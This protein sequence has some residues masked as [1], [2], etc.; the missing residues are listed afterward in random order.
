ML[1][2]P[3]ECCQRIYVS[4]CIL[5]ALNHLLS[6]HSGAPFVHPILCETMNEHP[7]S[8][9]PACIAETPLSETRRSSPSPTRAVDSPLSEFRKDS[10]VPSDV[11]YPKALLS[12]K[13]LVTSIVLR[14]DKVPVASS[15]RLDSIQEQHPL[16]QECRDR[17][18]GYLRWGF[19]SMYRKIFTLVFVV[20]FIPLVV[21]LSQFGHGQ[22]AAAI[23]RTASTAAAANFCV[24]ICM[25]NEHVVNALFRIACTV[26]LSAPL[27]IRRQFAKV[28]S[29]GGAHSAC[30]T[31]GSMWYFVYYALSTYGFY[32]AASWQIGVAVTSGVLVL[33]LVL[34]LIFAHPYLRMRHHDLFEQ[35]HRFAGWSAIAAFW[36]QV[37]LSASA[38]PGDTGHILVRT[39]AFWFL[40]VITCCIIYPWARLRS[41]KVEVEVLSKH[42]TRLHFDYDSMVPAAGVRLTDSALK[43]THA[44]ATIPNRPDQGKGFSVM[45][46]NAGDW[47][48][49]I[50]DNPPDR[51]WVRGAPTL[52]VIKV[53]L[54]FK[55]VLIIATGSGIGPCLSLLQ[56]MPGYPVRVIWSAPTPVETWGADIAQAV[57]RADPGA[58]IVD[59]RKTGRPDLVALAYAAYKESGAEAVVIIS[60]PKVTQ[61]VVYGMESRGV[62]AFGAIFDS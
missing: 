16:P 17:T 53:S 18:V 19:F 38:Q 41:R 60:N 43:E 33:L 25:R 23:S 14:D 12:Q 1:N 22:S 9:T 8:P 13:Y 29:Y 28:Y 35:T 57:L 31:S 42:A 50:I 30:T 46:S 24:G 61:N 47:T 48:R 49:K 40:I 5:H 36:V 4:S 3:L 20:N 26:P 62:P 37:G 7:T 51:L 52:G 34:I 11:P 58:I 32:V 27:A 54:L 55:K 39:P 44:F 2:L 56:G 45:V 10:L 6:L 21:I 59:T 15:A